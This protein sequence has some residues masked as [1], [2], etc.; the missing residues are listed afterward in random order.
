MHRPWLTSIAFIFYKLFVD[1]NYFQRSNVCKQVFAFI[2]GQRTGRKHSIRKTL[3]QG[4]SL[5]TRWLRETGIESR[6]VKNPWDRRTFTQRLV[7]RKILIWRL[8]QP[9]HNQH[10]TK[11]RLFKTV[12]LYH[13]QRSR[14]TEYKN[15]FWKSIGRT[16]LILKH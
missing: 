3:W 2:K 8:C 11:E 4:L 1:E 14:I 7:P 15:N 13:I 9:G 16:K 5:W 12:V 6:R 10:V